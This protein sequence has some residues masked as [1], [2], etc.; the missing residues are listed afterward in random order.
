MPKMSG[1]VQF[2]SK[3]RT[4]WNLE[5]RD[6]AVLLG[7][8]ASGEDRA[9]RILRGLEPLKD[10]DMKDRV[11]YLLGIRCV[12]DALL[13]DEVTENEWLREPHNLL[14]NKSPMSLLLEGSMR[15]M[16]RVY[17]YVKRAGGL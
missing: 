14:D 17:E 9:R 7:L 10:S 3:L 6:I 12:L 16:I 8:D 4:M 1:P 15:N 5:F 2:I 11:V 13:R